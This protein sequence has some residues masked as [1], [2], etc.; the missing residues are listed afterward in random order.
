MIHPH[1]P[2]ASS[3]PL[4][5]LELLAYR[6]FSLYA[7]KSVKAFSGIVEDQECLGINTFPHAHMALTLCPSVWVSRDLSSLTLPMG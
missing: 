2:Q 1:T 3:T 4:C 6:H 5:L 7:S